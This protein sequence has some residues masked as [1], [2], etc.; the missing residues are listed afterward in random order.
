[1]KPDN[2]NSALREFIGTLK[3]AGW[4]ALILIAIFAV[5]LLCGK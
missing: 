4:I 1:M 2:R 5:A 3:Y